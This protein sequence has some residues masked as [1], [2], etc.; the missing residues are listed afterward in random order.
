MRN[1]VLNATAKQIG[2][3]HSNIM[4][5]V[6]LTPSHLG[7]KFLGTNWVQTDRVCMHTYIHEWV[8]V[9]LPSLGVNF[10]PPLKYVHISQGWMVNNIWYIVKESEKGL[11]SIN[12]LITGGIEQITP[13]WYTVQSTLSFLCTLIL[14]LTIK[15][16]LI[17]FGQWTLLNK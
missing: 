12:L 2:Q 10:Q 16:Y 1:Q 13:I 15:V 11:P 5:A 3:S 8:Y 4:P 9:F 7:T 17:S 14:H 6:C